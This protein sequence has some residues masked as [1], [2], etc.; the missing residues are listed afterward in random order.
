MITC[1]SIESGTLGWINVYKAK[2]VW[3]L[4][5]ILHVKV[6]VVQS[7][8]TLCDPMDCNPWNF[9][10]QNTGVGS[11]SLFQGIFPTQGLNPGLPHCRQI[12]CQLSHQG[13]PG[14][15]K[16]IAYPCS[17]VLSSWPRSLTGASCIVWGF[18][19]SWAT[20]EFCKSIGKAETTMRRIPEVLFNG[21]LN[22]GMILG[23][24][25]H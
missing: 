23:V 17:R 25:A 8:L 16:W 20:R 22:S 24:L 10:G 3:F 18:F 13:S 15:L 4:P 5:G 12:L 19:T 14:I 2:A 7:Y 11:C 1:C 9:P 6:N 21:K